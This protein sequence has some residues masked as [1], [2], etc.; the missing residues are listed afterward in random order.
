MNA[1]TKINFHSFPKHMKNDRAEN[2]PIGILIHLFSY[3]E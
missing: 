1:L 2:F 3:E